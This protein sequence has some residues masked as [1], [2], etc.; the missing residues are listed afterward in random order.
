VEDNQRISRPARKVIAAAAVLAQVA[1]LFV[2]WFAPG[3]IAGPPWT[4][5]FFL[6]WIVEL[7]ATLV[8]ARRRP[9]AAPLVPL[10][11]LVLGV[12]ALMVGEPALGWTR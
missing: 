3:M 5:A 6:A 10:V 7:L 11:S 9:L 8:L 2:Y 1:L 12:F 4:Y